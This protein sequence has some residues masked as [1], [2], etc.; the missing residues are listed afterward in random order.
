MEPVTRDGIIRPLIEMRREEIREGLEQAG[1]RFREDASNLDP[2]RTRN[3]IRLEILPALEEAFP[4]AAATLAATAGILADEDAYLDD[5]A[6]RLLAAAERSPGPLAVARTP[7]AGVP[8]SRTA[9]PRSA[10]MPPQE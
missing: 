5:R 8:A 9:T 10:P 4:A 7:K 6:A 3:R 2:R 1:E